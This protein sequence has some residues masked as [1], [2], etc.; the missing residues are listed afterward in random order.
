[1]DQDLIRLGGALLAISIAFSTPGIANYMEGTHDTGTVDGWSYALDH[2]R[3]SGEGDTGLPAG[4]GTPEVEASGNGSIP[5]VASGSAVAYLELDRAAR[6]REVWG[7]GSPLAPFAERL[8]T[9]SDAAG[10]DWRIPAA[11]AVLES[12]AG[13]QACGGNAWGLG[14]CKG[15]YGQYESFDIGIAAVVK[16]LASQLYSGLTVREVFCRWVH[17]DKSCPT[18]HSQEYAA[19]GMKIMEVLR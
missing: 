16:T 8:V 1:M 3:G 17:G 2:D 9:A 4:A 6:A 15:E 5:A 13:R 7:K 10:I 12:S 14:A 19:Q 18:T 11:M